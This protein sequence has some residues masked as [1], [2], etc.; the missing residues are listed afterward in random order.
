MAK[1]KRRS[2]WEQ[3]F[4]SWLNR[5]LEGGVFHRLCYC[6]AV[7]HCLQDEQP[8][9]YWMIVLLMLLCVL[10]PLLLF[11]VP[12]EFL[13]GPTIT[14]WQAP[15]YLLGLFAAL[16]SS[17]GVANLCMPFVQRICL[18]RLRKDFPQGF[19]VPFYLGHKV[20]LLF[21]GGCGTVAALCALGIHY[22]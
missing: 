21:L 2:K 3:R 4:F 11:V 17:I 14:G 8:L 1:K 20:T 7:S 22:L 10:L 18:W 5:Q 13:D 9:W 12:I 16:L 6:T 15:L 19:A